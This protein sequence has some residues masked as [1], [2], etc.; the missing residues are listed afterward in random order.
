MKQ[1]L[2]VI[3]PTFNEERNIVACLASVDWADEILVV[4]SFSTD[5]TLELAR[6]RATRV[7]EHEYVNSATQKNWTIPQAAHDWVMILDAD[8]QV[9]PELAGEIREILER[10]P[11][12]DGYVI[13][14]LNHFHGQP[15]RHGGWGRDKVLRLFNKEKGSYQDK[16]VHAE[17]EV[18]GDIGE[19]RHL[20]HHDTFRGFDD[21][22]R[23]VERYAGWGAEDLRRKGRRAR[24]VDLM[25]RPLARFIKRYV[26]QRGFL[27]GAAGLMISGIDMYAV[28]L[29]YARLWEK[30]NA[31]R[32][33]S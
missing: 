9:S 25:F 6:S 32:D 4:D 33:R 15:I 8:E 10:G 7:L 5:K 12:K 18:R 19:L 30:E 16:H 2:T 1:Q 3:V 17:V 13:K 26:I 28:F 31:A 14:R 29:K 24:S 20:I 22:M 27:D 23:K 11:S 21:Y